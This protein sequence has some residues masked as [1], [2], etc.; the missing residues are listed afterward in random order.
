MTEVVAERGFARATV[1]DVIRR[2]GV[3]RET[4][5]QQFQDKEDCFL[6]AL[7]GAAALLAGG[8]SKVIADEPAAP[9]DRLDAALGAYLDTLAAEPAAAR[10]FLVE[11]Y[12]AGD[13]AR[14][15]R[16]AMLESFVELVIAIVDADDDEARFRCE[17]LVGAV[18]SMVTMRVVAGDF[19]SLPKLREPLSKLGRELLQAPGR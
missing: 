16:V 18:S 5:Y 14:A 4:F 15:R 2:A 3:S 1:Q 12:G 11:V 7:D 9:L 6:A 10:T 13:Q 8:V 19:E 17:A